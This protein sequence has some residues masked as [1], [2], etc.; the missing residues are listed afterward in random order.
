ML[1]EPLRPTPSQGFQRPFGLWR[2]EAW[3]GAAPLSNTRR[4]ILTAALATLATPALATEVQRW[5]TTSD[6]V[7]L[8]YLDAGTGRTVVFVP[9]WCMPASIFE[10]QIVALSRRWRVVS[11]DPRGQG[12]SEVPRSGYD[13]A[14]RG[15]DIRDLLQHV[16]PGR[17]VLAGWSLGVLDALSYADMAGDQRLAGLVLIDNS[18]GEGRAPPPRS[19]PSRFF[20][21]LRQRRDATVRGFVASMY[22]TPQDPAYLAAIAR[23]AQR[24]PVEASIRLLSYPRPREFWK[25]SLYAVRRPV[26]YAVTPRLRDQAAEVAQNHPQPMVEVFDGAGHALFVDEAARFNASMEEFL[27]RRAAWG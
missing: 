13:P 4:A 17:V 9:G 15:Q 27:S 19:T 1:A 20:I 5:F 16:G 8:R 25:Q 7:R 24:M 26:Y 18:V 14:R 2:G 3:R 10:P 6:G 11:L 12:E 22:R 21:N 23:Q